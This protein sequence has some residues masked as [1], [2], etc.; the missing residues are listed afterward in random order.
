VV[1]PPPLSQLPSGTGVCDLGRRYG[2]WKEGGQAARICEDAY[3]R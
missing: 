2:H 1:A 3:G